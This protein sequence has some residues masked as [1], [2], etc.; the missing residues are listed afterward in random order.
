MSLV[1]SAAAFVAR[2]SRSATYEIE[3][4]LRFD[5]GASL[6]RSGTIKGAST[7]SVWI[8]RGKL[9]DTLGVLGL[10]E[11]ST[12]NYKQLFFEGSG[13][14]SLGFDNSSGG[15]AYSNNKFRDPAAWFHVVVVSNTTG[16]G[17]K[18]YINGEEV[19]YRLQNTTTSSDTTGT[20][21][22]GALNG[23]GSQFNGYLAE[24]HIVDSALDP[25]DF[26][27][28]DENGVWRPIE[29][30]GSY[31]SNGV[32]LK[33]DETAA[34]GIG[35]DHSGN[36]NNFTASGFTT[37]G[38]QRD[39][40][41][42]TPTDNHCTLNNID[43]TESGYL[44]SFVFSEGNLKIAFPSSPPTDFVSGT[45]FS[46]GAWYA[47]VECISVTRNANVNVLEPG[48]LGFV[49][50]APGNRTNPSSGYSYSN[51]G[52]IRHGGVDESGAASWTAGDVIGVACNV[53]GNSLRFYKNGVLQKT[54]TTTRTE[55]MT[56]GCDGT[57][58]GGNSSSF[59]INCGQQPYQYTP[60]TGFTAL[61]TKNLPAPTIKDG[62]KNFNTVKF[63]AG[64]TTVSGVGFQPD[65]VWA[66]NRDQSY[67]HR[68]I[69]AVRGVKND[70]Y[71]N[72]TTAEQTNQSD[73]LL[74]FT[75]D[76]FTHGKFG[77]AD[78]ENFVAWNWKANGSGSSNT[79]GDITSTV[80]ANA[81]AGFSIVTYTGT[82]TAGDGFGHGLGVAP[83]MVLIKGRSNADNWHVY[84]ESNGNTGG[85]FLNLTNAFTTSQYFWNN[86][87]PSST[88]VTLSS[89]A[90]NNQ[91]GVTY[92]A[93]CF[94]EV[95]G[96]SKF[97]SYTGNGSAN[98]G[99]FLYCGFKPAWWMV[100]RTDSTES[101]YIRDTTR[102]S[103]NPISDA[104]NPNASDAEGSYGS[105]DFLSNG[106]KIRESG[107]GSNTSG[108]TYIYAA[109][110]ENPF[111]G[112]GV[113]PAT[114]R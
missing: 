39:T 110:A 72:A 4:S 16:T 111:G 79:D 32:Y 13:Y 57:D 63:T 58:G 97:G 107:T 82:G 21:Y 66:K 95:E 61:S 48:A 41:T 98:E 96:Y 92:V 87:S 2:N 1:S 53:D 20:I 94:A 74:T 93:Y 15:N 3:Q 10:R 112:S 104:L 108:G 40:V 88:V 46:T 67:N 50:S 11:G 38:A 19:S 34:N 8:K 85:T 102:D 91:S 5:G 90:S 80:S 51:S 114:A 9:N 106:I 22:I 101:W 68:L 25:T 33:F 35:H 100:K 83:K 7:F 89:S 52:N 65:W 26:A 56:I 43:Q 29:F 44:S 27:E 14:D 37:T 64:T 75:S 70:L 31:G 76:G 55:P 30:T 103:I 28:E 18:M 6:S 36:G 73:S 24:L 12:S 59:F 54:Y 62:S 71:S 69:D 45:L 105:F 60:P 17:S 42:D 47:E 86:T 84:H 81:T 78:A 113:S 109:F 77:S 23:G 49:G 99:P